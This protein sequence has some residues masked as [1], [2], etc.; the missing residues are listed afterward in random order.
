MARIY[1]D[2]AATT[3]LDPAVLEAML[4]WMGCDAGFGN[5][6]SVTHAPGRAAATAVE[7]ARCRVADLLQAPVDG[8]IF[9]GSATEAINMAV[10][11]SM[12]F[13]MQRGRGSHLVTCATEHTAVLAACEQLR[14]EGATVTV[15]PVDAGGQ[16]S[17]ADLQEALRDDTVLVSLMLGNNETGVCHDIAAVAAL[18]QGHPAGLHVDAT[19]AVGKVPVHLPALQ[20]DLL[21]LSAH[22]FHGPKGVGALWRCPEPR[23]RLQPLLFGGG[24]ESGERSGTQAVHQIVG[25][26]E[27]C[28]LAAEALPAEMQ[29]LTALRD[30]LEAGL[31]A[32]GIPLVC[33]GA[34][35]RL[36]HISNLSF[37]GLHGEALLADIEPELAV[38]LGS[39]CS[40]ADARGSHVLRAM[41]LDETRSLSAFRF[42][43]GRRTTPA[44]IDDAVAV[45][46]RS[47]QR[48]LSLSPLQQRGL[49]G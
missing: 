18:L 40:S 17:L 7:Q 22:K 46:A 6:A 3:P 30:R 29:R 48:L 2:H 15:L 26:G 13:S 16:L 10:L 49:T 24:Q 14:R 32:T 9:T 1:L 36:P 33:N 38:A 23:V 43:V 37:P 35:R 34:G 42:S 31:R 20:A 5:P 41:G 45:V 12:R 19:Q 8:V 21:S 28:G 44:D 27:A 11:G 25:L 4:P 47:V 39:A